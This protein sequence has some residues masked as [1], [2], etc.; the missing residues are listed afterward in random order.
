MSER[1][2]ELAYERIQEIN[3]NDE[4]IDVLTDDEVVDLLNHLSEEN[5]RLHDTVKEFKE[6]YDAQIY[7]FGQLNSDF[8]WL[9]EDKRDLEKENK[10][11]KQQLD[12]IPENIRKV[13]LE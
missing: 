5:E 4:I 7:L 1:R 11:L 9:R 10:E 3:K 6:R 13:W 2:F 12:K 8:H